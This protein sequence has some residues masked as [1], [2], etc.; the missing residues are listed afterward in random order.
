MMPSSTPSQTI[1]PFFA[2]LPP[3]GTNVLVSSDDPAAIRVVGRIFDGAGSPVADALV[4]A[5]QA[6]RWGRYRHPADTQELPLEE[7][8]TGFGRCPTLLDGRFEF[9]TVKPGCVAY[10]DS[11][12]QAPHIT[13]TILAR[14]LLRHLVTRMYF[15]DEG[16]ANTIDPV[17]RS[18][19]DETERGTLIA[20]KAGANVYE[21]DIHLQGERETVF[22]AV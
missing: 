20:K 11:R 10:I 18:L 22:F 7:S 3:L 21:F 9:V 13:L 16:E 6:N 15:E 17:L 12:M 8:F 19:P 2:I 1:G 4:E 14:G 5:W